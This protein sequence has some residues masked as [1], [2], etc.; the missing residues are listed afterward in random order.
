MELLDP[1]HPRLHS[2]GDSFLLRSRDKINDHAQQRGEKKTQSE[3]SQP[4]R[5]PNRARED[6]MEGGRRYHG[7]SV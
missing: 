1:A 7:T 5:W 6:Q 2:A 4:C 3:P